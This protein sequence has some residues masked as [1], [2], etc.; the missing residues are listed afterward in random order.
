MV[1]RP[2]P[3]SLALSD[4][5]LIVACTGR[6]GK[7]IPIRWPADADVSLAELRADLARAGWS[8]AIGTVE[9]A[10]G[11]AVLCPNCSRRVDGPARGRTL[12]ERVPT[13]P[14]G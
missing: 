7:I 4:L 10:E 12:H 5:P 13:M 11:L 9:G 1:D 6:C 14:R 2:R 8:A 3:S